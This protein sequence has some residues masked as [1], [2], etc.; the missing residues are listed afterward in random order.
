MVDIK[1]AYWIPNV[2]GGLVVSK[3]PQ[4]TN[5]TY[6]YNAKIVRIA[7]NVGFDYALAQARF[8]ASYGAEYQLEALTTVAALAPVTK[9]LKLI[10]AVHPG[11]W[12]P[13]VVAKMGATIDFLSKG[14]FCLN[15]VSGWFKNEFTIYGEPW[16]DHDKILH[17]LVL[18]SLYKD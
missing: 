16:L 4:H 17:R 1:F 14:R 12:H 9:K 5:W 10:A 7:E 2:S 11:L 3:I 18:Y 6:D 8:I 13:G 15:V